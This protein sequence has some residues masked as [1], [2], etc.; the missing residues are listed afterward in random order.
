MIFHDNLSAH[1]PK[2]LSRSSWLE[3]D[4]LGKASFHSYG[5]VA[6]MIARELKPFCSLGMI[7]SSGPL[8][9]RRRISISTDGS[10]RVHT[11]HKTSC[12]L[13]GSMSSSTTMV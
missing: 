1:L 10:L 8:Q 4:T 7:G 13:V 3:R 5:R 9:Q 12:K 6:S 11:A 2:I